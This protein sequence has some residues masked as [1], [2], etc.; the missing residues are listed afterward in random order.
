MTSPR[1]IV[2]PEKHAVKNL[3]I[4]PKVQRDLIPNWVK[5]LTENMREGSIGT[6]V[7]SKRKMPSG[8]AKL[9]VLDGQHRLQALRD[10]GM[11]DFE[12]M[13]EVHLGLDLVAEAEKFRDLNKQRRVGPY[14]DYVKGVTAQDP[15]CMAIHKVLTERGLKVGQQSSPGSV[16]A[17]TAVRQVHRSGEGNLAGTLDIL[18]AAYGTTVDAMDGSLIQGVGVLVNRY[19]GELDR[20]ALVRKLSKRPGG[21]LKLLGDARGA[22]DLFGTTVPRCV[23]MVA[24]ET[25]NRGRNVGQLPPL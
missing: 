22:K 19:N 2:V 15:E 17:I 8:K 3:H 25:Y 10:L 11:D 9:V 13:C 24:R 5:Y 21:P 1:R 6:L 12:V 4:D 20:A 18:T 16:R 14:D 23:A 7:V